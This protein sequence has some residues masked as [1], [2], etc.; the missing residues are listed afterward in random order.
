[1]AA[2]KLE[3]R[4]NLESAYA[5]V[6][7]PEA[8][9]TLEALAPLDADRKAVMAAR[10]ER[11]TEKARMRQWLSFLSPQDIIPRT[12]ITVQNARAGRFIGSEIPRDLQR[13]WIQ[14]TGAFGFAA[15]PVP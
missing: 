13:Q 15:G 9:A 12:R 10:M 7:T 8:V 6:Y 1:M 3:I 2:R 14:G 4:G 5:D 11:R